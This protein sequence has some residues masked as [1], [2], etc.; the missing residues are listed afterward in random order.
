MAVIIGAKP[1][2]DFNHPLDLMS[3]C[4]RRIERFLAQLLTVAEQ[5]QGGELTT[6]QREALEAALRYFQQAAPLHNH[7]EEESLFPRLH[8]SGDPRAGAVLATIAA[9]EKEH[10]QAETVHAEIDRRGR[11]WLAEGRLSPEETRRLI[12]LLQDLQD[13]YRRHIAIE[14]RVV[15]PLAAGLL[16]PAALRALGREMAARRGIDP[17]RPLSLNRCGARRAARQATLPSA[18]QE[19]QG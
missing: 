11:R 9:L 5:A 8:A 18:D 16:E 6:P 4:H 10:R 2:S 3:D 7:D 13:T 12:G 19:K 17:D 1:D 15:F 14:D